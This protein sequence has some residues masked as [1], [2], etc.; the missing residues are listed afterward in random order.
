[1]ALSSIF[2]II[3]LLTRQIYHTYLVHRTLYIFNYYFGF[4]PEMPIF[5]LPK[6]SK[7]KKIIIGSL[8]GSILLFGW[9]SLSWTML[10]LHDSEVKYTPAQDTLMSVISNHI[11]EDGQY[12]M[13]S[14]PAGASQKEM[15]EFGKKMEG[16]PWVSLTYHSSGSYDM[17]MPIIRGFFICLVCIILVCW[18]IQRLNRKSFTGIFTTVM[19][20]AAICFLFVWYNGHNW[21]DTPWS[22][23]YPELID[24]VAGW[25][26]A[27]IWLGWWYSRKSSAQS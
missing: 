25:G 9:S 8:V 24:L 3:R 27:A 13:L 11:K 21:F 10:H 17:V 22:V 6:L 14:L 1:M 26:L 2:I 7:M 16:K 12:M 23:L 19:T 18:I 15:D 4:P 5:L 20:F